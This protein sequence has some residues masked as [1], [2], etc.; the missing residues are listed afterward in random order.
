[1]AQLKDRAAKV[2]GKIA[3]LLPETTTSVRYASFD[4]PYL[5]KAFKAAG[6]TADQCP[7]QRF[8]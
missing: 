6:L 2:K 5:R 7:A 1:M 3:V 8:D 4:Q